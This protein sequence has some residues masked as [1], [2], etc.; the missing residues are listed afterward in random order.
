MDFKLPITT[1]AFEQLYS[2]ELAHFKIRQQH[3]GKGNGLAAAPVVLPQLIKKYQDNVISVEE[4][5]RVIP[6]TDDKFITAGYQLPFNFQE[7]FQKFRFYWLEFPIRLHAVD[8]WRFSKVE[9]VLSF[10]NEAAAGFTKPRIF[11]IFPETKFQKYFDLSA[12]AS[13]EVN[14][15]L[16]A[17]LSF[18]VAGQVP[19]Y[20][21][22]KADATGSGKVNTDVKFFVG[23]FSFEVKKC[24]IKHDVTGA[25]EIHWQ[26]NKTNYLKENNLKIV[27]ILQVPK[28]TKEV[29]VETAM[30]AYKNKTFAPQEWLDYI[31]N[32]GE[33]FRTWFDD[34][35]PIPF[36]QR[37][38]LSAQLM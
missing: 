21:E 9:I 38:D 10:N 20:G 16:D 35:L 6:I 37:Y 29:T 3:L 4:P 13:G 23:P 33:M 14:I 18:N 12:E 27:V 17:N 31:K 19:G 2:N 7:D 28:D 32:A 34:D 36:E 15:G 24:I 8:G 26:L 30:V 25:N 11:K 1:S 22:V 5:S